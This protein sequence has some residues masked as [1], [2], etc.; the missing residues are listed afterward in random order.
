MANSSRKDPYTHF[1]KVIGMVIKKRNL[2]IENP[3]KFAF[4]NLPKLICKNSDSIRMRD[5]NTIL[6]YALDSRNYDFIRSAILLKENGR[7]VC[8]PYIDFNRIEI[9]DGEE[10]T[11]IQFIDK[12]LNE[13]G[14]G[15]THDFDAIRD[16]RN[17]IKGCI[18]KQNLKRNKNLNK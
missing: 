1:M 11:L 7:N 3:T 13:D 12:L 14:M 9:I 15:A 5:E 18:K 6:K 4:D 8:N 10:E 2:K 17:D 16:I